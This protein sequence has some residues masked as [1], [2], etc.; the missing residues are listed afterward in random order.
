M[1]TRRE[2]QV[3]PLVKALA[4]AFGGV[5][6]TSAFAQ[7]TPPAT[8]QELQ[9]VEVTGSS[10]KRIQAEGA[11]PVQIITQE[12][13]KRSGATS[14]TDLI[15]KIPAMQGFTVAADSVNGGGGGLTTANLRGIGN[16]YTLVLING[17]RA[18][19]STTGSIINLNTLPLTAIERVEVLTD[20]A[21][22][23]YGSDAIA[24][25][26]NFI[27]KKNTTEGTVEL[28][29]EIPTEGK[30]KDYRFALSKGFGD[31]DK[32]RF[33]VFLSLS[34]EKQ[35]QLSAKD[36][37]FGQS[38]RKEFD[39]DGGRYVLFQDSGNSVPGNI[40]I[41][42]NAGA[43]GKPRRGVTYN[44]YFLSTNGTCPENTFI[45][46]RACRYDFASTVQ[47]IP[48]FNL[49]TFYGSGRFKLNADTQFFGEVF[50]GNFSTKPRFA[51]P[52]QGLSLRRLVPDSKPPKYEVVYQ[53][54]YDRYVIPNLTALGVAPSDITAVNMNLRL[55]DA[56]GRTDEYKYGA[57]HFVG[58]VEGSAAGWDYT[59][60]LTSSSVKFDQTYKGGY[61]SG[62]GFAAAVNGGKFDPF[63]LAGTEANI[64]ALAPSVLKGPVSADKSTVTS[65]NF[66][67]SRSLFALGGG[68]AMLG[69]GIDLTKQRYVSK[70]SDYSQ[71]NNSLQP[72]FTDTVLG[73]GQGAFPF[74]TSRNVSGIFAEFVTPFSK[75]LEVTAALRYDKYSAAKN[76][77]NFDDKGNQLAPETQGKSFGGATYKVGM[78]LQPTKQLL[79]RAS[80]GTGLRAPTL[81]NLTSPFQSAGVTSG[82]YECPF[83]GS[84]DPR[85]AGCLEPDSQYNIYSAGNP[86]TNENALKAEK[87]KQWNLGVRI[88]PS[89]ALSF[90][91]DAW[92]IQLRDQI[93]T[94]PEVVAFAA[95]TTTYSDI[96]TVIPDKVSGI[97]TVT[98]LSRPLNLNRSRYSG[99]DL[100][101][102]A[103]FKTSVGTIG[104]KTVVAITTKNEYTLPGQDGFQSSLGKIGPNGQMASRYL[105]KLTGTWDIGE[106]ANSMT[107]NYR[108]GYKDAEG[109]QA[110]PVYVLN[111]DGTRGALTDVIRNVSSYTTVDIQSR[112]SLNK[113]FEIT[114][115]IRNLL[116]AKPP[117]TIQSNL[118]GNQVG[119]DPRYSDAIGR[120]IALTGSY[121]F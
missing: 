84:A 99:V 65:L 102:S 92:S 62:Q 34:G 98:L 72:N 46:G 106:F 37:A 112:Y 103:K 7:T 58:G 26:V 4:I 71:G 108:P 32:D 76:K 21:S 30:A 54:L 117:L 73:G 89:D 70:P 78:R 33:N 42:R 94:V 38:G 8:P 28:S 86:L 40:T 75:A 18:A 90:G 12:E 10:V 120:R 2:L 63:T 109:D 59:A 69:A 15:Q 22:A 31:I 16:N 88:E 47:L 24:G 114:L 11:L 13:I 25:V 67:G 95:A 41:S 113:A 119:Y 14:V 43:D 56:G 85:S 6:A 45:S 39:Y 116:N 87:S 3:R 55:F 79:L 19:P 48:D 35:E 111:A 105:L 5:M 27:M 51:P 49:L 20:G 17:R 82:S 97:P 61:L 100:D 50:S 83:Q 107:V 53:N 96:F 68:D 23:L 104:A 91:V 115:G 44:P 81:A 9:R 118:S 60:S 1:S 110:A 52:A 101:A 77:Q 29:A 64:A 36:R 80:Y 57:N 66:K 121:K 93:S 74:D